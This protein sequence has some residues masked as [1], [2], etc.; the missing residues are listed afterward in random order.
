M[1]IRK[2]IPK[3]V[4]ASMGLTEGSSISAL[5]D[6]NTCDYRIVRIIKQAH[7]DPFHLHGKLAMKMNAAD[8]V[9]HQMPPQGEEFDDGTFCLQNGSFVRL[10]AHEYE[11]TADADIFAFAAVPKNQVSTPFDHEKLLKMEGPHMIVKILSLAGDNVRI[12]HFARFE[13]EQKMMHLT[14]LRRD[15]FFVEKCHY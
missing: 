10:S 15:A 12:S 3:S 7:S 2:V 5:W 4:A 8:K 14:E 6:I 1:F 13:C 9:G 11:E